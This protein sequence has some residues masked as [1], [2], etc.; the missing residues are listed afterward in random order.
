MPPGIQ[1]FSYVVDDA[2]FA[3]REGGEIRGGACDVRLT[4]VRRDDIFELS[5]SISGRVTVGCDRCLDDMALD[6]ATE[7]RTTLKYA[8]RSNDDN[9]EVIEVA[10]G[11]RE[12]DLSD[13]IYD[14]IA[15]A[16]PMTHAHDDEGDCNAEMLE[17]LRRCESRGEEKEE[18]D[19]RWNA[20]RGLLD[21]NSKNK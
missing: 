21:K 3:M 5:F 9:D 2:F 14:T 12:Y 7:Y 15:L 16:V 10:E 17:R 20:L 18:N 19:P 6:I 8:E 1:Q 11:E 13:I 4:A